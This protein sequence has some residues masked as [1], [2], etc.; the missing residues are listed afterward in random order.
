[1]IKDL[2]ISLC[3]CLSLLSDSTRM[4]LSLT[5]DSLARY[6]YFLVGEMMIQRFATFP[7]AP[8]KADI[9]GVNWGYSLA[10]SDSS[11]TKPN[12]FW[13]I[14]DF[15]VLFSFCITSPTEADN[16][17]FKSFAKVRN[18]YNSVCM[19]TLLNVILL[20][21]ESVWCFTNQLVI[22]ITILTLFYTVIWH[23]FIAHATQSGLLMVSTPEKPLGKCFTCV[24]RQW[25]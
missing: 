10:E 6:V 25:G 13:L 7:T 15:T 17:V 12:P 23:L 9:S 21:Y 18:L 2:I 19:M 5:C 1:M 16:S 4:S 24:L 22:L 20:L 14:S 8:E 11:L 3:I